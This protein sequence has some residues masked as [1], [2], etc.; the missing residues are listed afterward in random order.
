[1][2]PML[3]PMYTGCRPFTDNVVAY[4]NFFVFVETILGRPDTEDHS[5]DRVNG[6]PGYTPANL[7]FADKSVQNR[8]RFTYR[9]RYFERARIRMP[10]IFATTKFSSNA[11]LRRFL[12]AALTAPKTGKRTKRKSRYALHILRS[13]VTVT[14][15]ICIWFDAFDFGELFAFNVVR[16]QTAED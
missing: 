11:N 16:N 5:L 6:N 8:N 15:H 4:L 10:S 14:K 2:G 7:R 3:E 13:I 9:V 1:M 12:K